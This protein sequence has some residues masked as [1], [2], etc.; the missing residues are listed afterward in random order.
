MKRQK[1][2]RKK[3]V[4]YRLKMDLERIAHSGLILDKILIIS[5]V[6][7]GGVAAFMQDS[8]MLKPLLFLY[9]VLFLLRV[10]M[11]FVARF[12]KKELAK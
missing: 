7:V 8:A 11:Y 2:T 4:Q 3:K 5:A 10:Y 1:M 9:G 6:P 12:I